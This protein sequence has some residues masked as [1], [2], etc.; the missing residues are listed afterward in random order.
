MG[1]EVYIITKGEI[2]R[3][4]SLEW[5]WGRFPNG[6]ELAIHKSLLIDKDRLRYGRPTKPDDMFLDTQKGWHQDKHTG[7]MA[8]TS[9][10]LII[11]PPKEPAPETKESLPGYPVMRD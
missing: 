4:I 11:D 2:I 9:D 3:D 5:V 10:K 6:R 7:G 8:Y 1:K